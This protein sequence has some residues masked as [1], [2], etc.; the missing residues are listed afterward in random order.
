[1]NNFIRKYSTGKRVLILFVITNVVYVIM[2][3]LTIPKTAAFAGGMKL[4]DM[5]PGGYNFDYV[6]QLFTALGEKGRHSYLFVQL[7]FDMVYPALFAI[8][9]CLLLAY[10][11]KK[12][13]KQ[14]GWLIYGCYLPLIGGLADYL[15]NL[16][17]ITLLKQFPEIKSQW[18]QLTSLFSVVKSTA[19]SVYFTVLLIV[20]I[21]VAIQFIRRKK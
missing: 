8:S 5:M 17:I 10:F 2:V 19:T 18:V 1:M 9:Y 3:A 11:L 12:L 20:L 16:G 4:L 21:V 15:E 6:Q 14:K 7:P 13:N